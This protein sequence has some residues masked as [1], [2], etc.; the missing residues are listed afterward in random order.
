MD[1]QTQGII[2]SARYVFPVASPVIREG[3]VFV[4]DGV[5]Q[6]VDGLARLAK[7]YRAEVM[8]LGNGILMPGFINGHVHLELGPM[9]ARLDPGDDFPA[10]I[11]GIVK[12]R[13]T[14]SKKRAAEGVRQGIDVLIRSGVAGVG[15]ISTM[16]IDRQPLLDAPLYT[17]L[18]RETT[19][20]GRLLGRPYVGSATMEERPFLHAPYST[21]SEVYREA[22]KRFS[23]YGTH[24]AESIDEYRLVTGQEN[25]FSRR[26]GPL[27]RRDPAMCR[28]SSPVDYL[29]RLGFIKSGTTLVH[30]VHTDRRDLELASSCGAGIVLCPRSNAY[31]GVGLPD[32]GLLHAYSRLG[33]GTDG[34]S[35]NYSLDMMDEIRFLYLISRPVLKSRAE[36]FVIGAATIA[37]ARALFIEDRLGSIEKGKRPG[38]IYL[39][40]DVA[41]NLCLSIINTP[42]SQIKNLYATVFGPG[43]VAAG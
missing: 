40:T 37:G 31:L 7:R 36:A 4:R 11:F 28:S 33:I 41:K 22:S 6:D 8:E 34:L 30:F 1:K 26:L 32:V 21:A 3:A 35:S 42:S 20:V 18:F 9:H 15:E 16:G 10:W 17:V 25:N 13:L 5:I 27:V 12:K 43:N 23:A 39:D 19:S 38:L 29:Y 24:I 2:L 14:L